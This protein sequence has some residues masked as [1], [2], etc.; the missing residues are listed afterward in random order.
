MVYIAVAVAVGLVVADF[1]DF[2]NRK[3]AR[4]KSRLV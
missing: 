3:S 4:Q 1:F 2:S